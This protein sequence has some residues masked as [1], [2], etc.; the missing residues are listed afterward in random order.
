MQI[1]ILHSGD[2]NTISRGGVDRYIK[3]LILF[4]DDGEITVFGTSARNEHTIGK[5]YEKEYCGKKYYFVPIIDDRKYPL[6]LRYMIKELSWL[7]VLAGYDCIYAQRT[8]YSLPFMFSKAKKKLVEMIHGSSKYSEV[9]WGRKKATIHLLIERLAISIASKT[10]IILN[11]DEFGV[12]YYRRKYPKYANR[13]EYGRNP[14][15]LGIYKPQDKDTIRK[16]LG[17]QFSKVILYSGRVE[18]TPKRVLLFPEIMRKVLDE[19][20]ECGF[21]ILGDGHDKEHLMQDV[22]EQKMQGNF[23]FAGYIDDPY[24]IAQYNCAA[25]VAINISMFEGTCTSNL[26]AIACGT[27]VVST[28]VGDIHECIVEGNNGIVIPNDDEMIVDDAA[29]AVIHVLTIGVPMDKSFEKYD[30]NMVINQ[31]KKSFI[32]S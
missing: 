10:F 32:D 28:D 4:C 3:S 26:E 8:E 23:V 31:L 22:V 7:K 12:P 20:I 30:G 16:K 9:F 18:D 25:D 27:P 17:I 15:D 11:R 5:K 13:I 2:L 6:S 24:I 14:I 29:A 1:A 21:I 19:G